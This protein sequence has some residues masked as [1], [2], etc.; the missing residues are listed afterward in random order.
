MTGDRLFSRRETLA[1][2]LMGA[3]APLPGRAAEGGSRFAAA[4]KEFAF[5]TGLL[6]GVL[7]GRGESKG[8]LPVVDCATGTALSKSLGLF[9]HY[10]LMDDTTR[11]GKAAWDW[12][13]A[14]SL[15]PDGAVEI[16]WAAD[17]THPFDMSA[18]YRWAGADTLDLK[19][20]V[21]ACKDLRQ[22][23]VFLASYFDGFEDASVSAGPGWCSARKDAGMWH[24]YP[25][26]EEAVRIAQDGRWKHPPHPVEWTIRERLVRS[27]VIRRDASRGLAAVLMASPEGCFAVATPYD[28]EGHRSAYLSLFGRDLKHGQ[29]VEARCRM[30]IGRG[31]DEGKAI[32]LYESFRKQYPES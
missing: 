5:D 14:A 23:E 30:V 11:Y 26:D 19:T 25:R 24:L 18:E 2:A 13:S 29:T 8:L 9:S 21:H 6:R 28:G 20:R 31:I 7:R 12:A 1:L 4:G 22:F 15:T 10:R 32:D 16:R 3:V 17:D 27:L